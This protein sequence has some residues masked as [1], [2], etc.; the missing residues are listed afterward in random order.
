MHNYFNT[1]KNELELYKQNKRIN[2]VGKF[3]P[4]NIQANVSSLK[5]EGKVIDNENIYDV[6]ELLKS[7]EYTDDTFVATNG[8]TVGLYTATSGDTY[9]LNLSDGINGATQSID[10]YGNI[11]LNTLTTGIMSYAGFIIN[12]KAP[13]IIPAQSSQN[14]VTVEIVGTSST[15]IGNGYTS[16]DTFITANPIENLGGIGLYGGNYSLNGWPTND[17]CFVRNPWYSYNTT[18]QLSSINIQIEHHGDDGNTGYGLT[19]KRGAQIKILTTSGW[20]VV[21]L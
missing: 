10:Q 1:F 12:F 9:S 11:Y 5:E 15:V 14:Q 16:W 21:T 2:N 8:A 13:I 17:I 7:F 20:Y 3:D 4:D 19:L 18:Q 6:I